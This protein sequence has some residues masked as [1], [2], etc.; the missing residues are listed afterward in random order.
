[1]H[2]WSIYILLFYYLTCAFTC[3]IV[4]SQSNTP[5]YDTT[6]VVQLNQQAV[7]SLANQQ[8]H[9][10]L[11]K[12]Q[13][14][15][16][17]AQANSYIQGKAQSLF[18]LGKISHHHKKFATSLNFF[19][20]AKAVYQ[21]L[22]QPS[23]I[24]QVYYEI[25]NLYLHWQSPTKA[26]HYFRQS[27]DLITA[28][29]YNADLMCKVLDNTGQ[30]YWRMELYKK[31]STVY[32]QLLGMQSSEP[33]KE[34]L[35]TLKK[36]AKIHK[37]TNA[38]HISLAYEQLILKTQKETESATEK[39]ITLNSIGFL[40][41]KLNQHTEAINAFKQSLVLYKRAHQKGKVKGYQNFCAIL[42]TNIGITYNLLQEPQQA[43]QYFME[44]MEFRQQTGD[45]LDIARLHNLIATNYCIR[46]NPDRAQ[47]YLQKAVNIAKAQQ[48]KE[49]LQNSYKV[50]IKIYEQQNRP[51]KVK[52]YY[53]LLIQLKEEIEVENRQKLKDLYTRQ[54]T[55]D[56]KEADYQLLLT[57][58]E[59]QASLNRKLQLESEKKGQ[60]LALKAS[61]L[62]LLRK[63]QELQQS[64]LANELLEKNKVKQLLSLAEQR[65]YTEEQKLLIDSLRNNKKLQ[66]LA[67]ERQ[68]AQDKERQ[69][70]IALLEKDRKLKQQVLHEE[71]ALRHNTLIGMSVLLMIIL[72]A[73][74]QIRKRNKMLKQRNAIIKKHQQESQQFANKLMKINERLK[75]KEKVLKAT[76][77]KLEQQNLEIKAHNFIL[78]DTIDELG[79]KNQHIQDSLHYAKRMQ[80][81]ML[82]YKA[83]MDAVF[84]EHF[85]IFK[86][87]EIVSG[88]FYWFAS[89]K[90]KKNNQSLALSHP[91]LL[92]AVVD[93]TGHG[94]PGGF[95]S[96]MGFALLNEIV[97]I[98]KVL[99]PAQI[100]Q[101]LDTELRQSL[102]QENS[103]NNDG[104]DICL[105]TLEKNKEQGHTLSFAGAKRPLYYVLPQ[106]PNELAQLPANRYSIGGNKRHKEFEQHC[107][108]LPQGSILYLSTDGMIHLP[109]SRRRNF[110]SS[111]FKKM[112]AHYAHLPLAKQRQAIAATLN[113]FQ[114]NEEEQRD[115]VT[116]VGVKV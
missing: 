22:Q 15:L 92:F 93:C 13:Q 73:I 95:L 79:R 63:D 99:A 98:E 100:L 65:L 10:A 33:A 4:H 107:L 16:R 11:R 69:Q 91:L 55:I 82:P 61:E 96:M 6:H 29:H 40:Y 36:L 112:L 1:M 38:Y 58:E 27:R 34:R 71:R 30:A 66:K 94:V 43:Q 35:R 42:L 64:I 97:H 39:A 75:N 52:A 49:V 85:V 7:E 50:F 14:A 60:N 25:G 26:L 44:A 104:M 3:T 9:L 31:A 114:K 102:K 84:Q 23:S 115:D 18:I 83:E 53:K 46:G 54:L 87:R 17:L 110:G 48:N 113:D 88:D 106:A 72:A 116:L 70:R 24:A 57:E 2:L 67:L 21:T 74:Y 76:N 77:T 5:P 62:S 41:K 105:C 103:T 12:A 19:L 47:E 28:Q 90:P 37:Q 56:Q 59:K 51:K 108:Q 45:A 32:Q 86:P 111:R 20:K 101:R 8:T 81:A 68:Q 80:E 89:V 78:S 109:N